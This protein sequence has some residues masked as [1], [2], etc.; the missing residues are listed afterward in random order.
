[1]K[2]MMTHYESKLSKQNRQNQQ[3]EAQLKL[4]YKTFSKG[5]KIG[6]DQISQQTSE[7]DDLLQRV[8]KSESVDD[9]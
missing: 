8:N 1:M 4:T 3:L 7:V 6:M 2:Q 9:N 5:S